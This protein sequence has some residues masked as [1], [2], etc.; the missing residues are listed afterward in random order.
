MLMVGLVVKMNYNIAIFMRMTINI[1]LMRH[2]KAN[3]AMYM[4]LH[5]KG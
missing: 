4:I 5:L 2:Q 3:L 1:N